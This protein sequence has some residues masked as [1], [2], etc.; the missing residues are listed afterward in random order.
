MAL[1]LDQV[2]ARKR[3][4]HKTGVVP[5]F[6]EV[7]YVRE[8]TIAERDRYVAVE[9]GAHLRGELPEVDALTERRRWLVSVAACDAEGNPLF[10]S[11]KD[12]DDMPVDAVEF[13]ASEVLRV[14]GL[15][16]EGREEIAG[17]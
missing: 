13:L 12:V 14:N 5:G 3:P 7:A 11:Q 17:N 9:V 16:A 1:T 15:T 6:E 2:R 10:E 4:V 8:I